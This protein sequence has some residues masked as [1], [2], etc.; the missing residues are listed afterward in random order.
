MC[1]RSVNR[2]FGCRA[3]MSSEPK[4]FSHNVG[5][6]LCRC[7]VAVV[8]DVVLVVQV[9]ECF[10][11][12]QPVP[13]ALVDSE[14]QLAWRE[15]AGQHSGGQCSCGGFLRGNA[16]RRAEGEAQFVKCRGKEIGD[17]VIRL[18]A[19][20]CGQHSQ[21]GAVEAGDERIA[22]ATDNLG[23]RNLAQAPEGGMVLQGECCR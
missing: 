2:S 17:V 3:R 10:D 7:P 20:A 23:R 9:G 16:A 19:C 22:G 4:G 8:E 6:D 1:F 13:E 11:Q 14:D 21:G 5:V 18:C 15:L 12:G